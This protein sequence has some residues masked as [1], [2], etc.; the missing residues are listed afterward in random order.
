MRPAGEIRQA[1]MKAA[2]ELA[3][4]DQGPTMR[5]LAARACVGIEAARSTVRDMTRHGHL[6]IRGERRVDYRNRPVAEYA[7]VTEPAP[8]PE[9]ARLVRVWV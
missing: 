3:R 9:T 6:M 7:P 8:E 4:P 5:E 1:V 2:I